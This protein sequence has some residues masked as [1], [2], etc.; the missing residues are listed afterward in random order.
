M[1][2]LGLELTDRCNLACAHCLREINHDC[3][4]LDP[5]LAERAIA[6]AARLGF[7]EAVF[8]GGE[9]TLHKSFVRLVRAAVAA[10]LKLTVVTNGQRPAPLFEALADAGVREAVTVA[11][12]LESADPERF[13]AVRGKRAYRR[14]VTACAGLVARKARIRLNA[15]IGP[16]NRTELPA[17]A[18]LAHQL[19]AEGLTV[20]S[21]QPT[22]GPLEG[23]DGIAALAALHTEIEA[24]AALAPLPVRLA[25]EPVTRRATHLCSTLALDE[26]NVN[27]RGEATFCCQLST[28]RDSAHPESVVVAELREG[29]AAVAAAQARQVAAF[30]ENKLHTWRD[31]V[32]EPMDAHP[33][34]YCL[35]TFGQFA[36]GG[37]RRAA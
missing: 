1:R 23:Y 24:A 14:F 5:A 20:T 26:I 12:S 30:L 13:D 32:P 22:S 17:I 29:V 6:E 11:L 27:H 15:T 21:Y 36:N 28:L 9:P 19:G 25:Y 16:W 3:S 37:L 18:A 35:R 10:G 34:S 2:R 8:T 7:A 31:G 4:D 33:C